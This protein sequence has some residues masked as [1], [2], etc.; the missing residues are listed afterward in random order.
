[1]ASAKNDLPTYEQHP[2]AVSLMPGGMDEQEFTAFCEDVEQRGIL[3]PV[4]LFE[5]K[6]LDG[7]HRYRAGH[8]TGT[9]W[10]EI[11][12][13]GKDPAGYIASINV[14]R[15][16]LGSLQR[17][18]V[19]ARLH[20]MH[21]LTQRE[22]CRKLGISNEVVNLVLKAMNSKNAKLIKRIETDSDFTRGML[23]EELEDAG[24]MR[25]KAD[26]TPLGANSVFALGGTPSPDTDGS[27]GDDDEDTSDLTIGDD[28]LVPVVGKKVSHSERRPKDSAA[29]KL[30]EA[31]KALMVDEKETFLRM[32]WPEANGIASDIGLFTPTKT[33]KAAPETT[34]EDTPLKALKRA[35]KKV[36]KELEEML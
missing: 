15:R 27:A 5:G 16:K 12:Y 6:V 13:K 30:S 28:F 20:T 29:Q 24:L 11:T 18:L 17:A 35:S 22:V 4:T 19:G 3:M 1:M 23:R 2:V 7:W 36:S 14:L 21:N 9:H 32:I 34:S 25:V 8:R 33:A 31:F 10:E 26:N